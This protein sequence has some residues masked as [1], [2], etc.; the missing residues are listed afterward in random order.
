[1]KSNKPFSPFLAFS[2]QTWKVA[3]SCFGFSAYG[4]LPPFLTGS[5]QT[6]DLRRSGCSPQTLTL[7]HSAAETHKKRKK[8]QVISSQY[9]IF[10]SLLGEVKIENRIFFRLYFAWGH[11]T[12][13]R[14]KS[15]AGPEYWGG[16]LWT[17]NGTGCHICPSPGNK[18]LNLLLKDFH[19][20]FIKQ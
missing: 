3:A 15:A 4:S 12:V 16:F 6:A 9:I 14:M 20:C 17:E 18:G 13:H 10:L 7:L 8:P 2:T 1:M 5:M 19:L 11:P